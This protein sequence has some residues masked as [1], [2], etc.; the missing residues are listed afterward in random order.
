MYLIFVARTLS[1]LSCSSTAVYSANYNV[2]TNVDLHIVLDASWPHN[3]IA[4]SIGYLVD[5][6]NVAH[7]GSN[8][9]LMNAKDGRTAF[10][11]TQSLGTF[12]ENYNAT[13]QQAS[14]YLN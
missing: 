7:F 14:E 8:I 3:S 13:V 12:F 9:T 6:V 10:D 5:N 4:K 2:D 1:D 11:S